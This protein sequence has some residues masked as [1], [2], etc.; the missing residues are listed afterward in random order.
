MDEALLQSAEEGT[1]SLRFYRWSEP[2]LSLGYFQRR[3]DRA[4]HAAS[5]PCRCVRRQSGGGAILHNLE[6]TYSFAAPA[7]SAWAKKP[8]ALYCAVHGALIETLAF[9]GIEAKL[10]ASAI[11]DGGISNDDPFLCFQRRSE[12]DVLLGDTKIAGSAQRRRRGAILQHGSLLLR[13]S[14]FAPE[15]PGLFDLTDLQVD[16]LA[17]RDAWVQSLAKRLTLNPRRQNLEDTEIQRARRLQSDKYR[18]DP[19]N[20]R[21]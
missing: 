15:L 12:A 18:S 9:F 19:W 10:S 14:P 6:W 3:A 21:R 11:D 20:L 16:E 17:L 8:A 13:G 4:N 2:T 5:L 1:C 7:L